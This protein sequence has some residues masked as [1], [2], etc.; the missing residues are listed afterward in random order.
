MWGTG[1][2]AV[3]SPVAEHRRTGTSSCSSL[4]LKHWL[5]SCVTH[6]LSC[7]VACGGFPTGDRTCVS[8]PG[9]WILYPRAP[10]EAPLHSLDFH[11]IYSIENPFNYII[12]AF[13]LTE[14]HTLLINTFIYSHP[15]GKFCSL[16][17]S[18]MV[19]GV[20]FNINLF[21][22]RPSCEV[23]WPLDF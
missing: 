20:F 11:N 4:V 1:L 13:F 21:K 8:F 17:F 12:V 18:F 10:R 7:S 14:F 22:V 23:W 3:A 19:S 16:V 9:T 5:N 6:G 2:V 15:T